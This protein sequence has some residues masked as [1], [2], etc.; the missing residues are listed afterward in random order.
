MGNRGESAAEK[1]K[2]IMLEV[3]C[4]QN[5]SGVIEETAGRGDA[6]TDPAR[7]I[8]DVQPEELSDYKTTT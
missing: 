6:D 5:V 8:S 3:K 2:V 7:K 1:Q 4:K